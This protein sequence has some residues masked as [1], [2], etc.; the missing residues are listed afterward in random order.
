MLQKPRPFTMT[1]F[2]WREV[3]TSIIQG[4]MITAGSLT[5]YQ[6]AV[7]QGF[8]EAI[9]RTM[10]FLVLISANIFLTLVNRSFYY[11][12]ITTLKYRNN[13]VP[14]IIMITITISALLLY[15]KPLSEFFGFESLNIRQLMISIAVG[16]LS[17]IWYELE[18]WR[19]R[20]S[21]VF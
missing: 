3:T 19:K 9:T 17:V 16:F 11:S 8:N 7:Q 4:L 21:D 15:I 10:V 14:L 12:I 18:K 2:S 13:L 6:Y 20:K 1:F 5:V